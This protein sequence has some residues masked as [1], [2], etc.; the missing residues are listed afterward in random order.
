[1]PSVPSGIKISVAIPVRNEEASIRA[2][3]DSLL[4]QTLAP[5]EIVITDGGSTDSTAAMITEYVER[6]APIHLLRERP[7]M[8][9]RGRNLAA[10]AATNEWI[11]FIDAGTHPEANWLESLTEAVVVEPDIDMV[12]GSYQPITDTFFKE[13]AAIAYVPPPVRVDGIWMRPRSIVSVLMRKAVWQSVNG[14]PEDLRSAEDLLFLDQVEAAGARRAYA[15]K[16]VVNWNIQPGWWK[17]FERFVTY[18]RNNIRAGLWRSWQ[19]TIYLRYAVLLFLTIVALFRGLVWILVPTGLCLLMLLA[20]GVVAIKR[21]RHSYPASLT[22]NLLR[23]MV[24]VPLL[25]MIDLAAIVGGL[26]WLVKD[27]T[28][29][30]APAAGVSHDT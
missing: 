2:L 11:A 27:R 6:G 19:A 4:N 22:T 5:D 20:R 25:A 7:G 8:P 29:I 17:T 30:P 3:L 13:C 24:L 15:P 28:I 14:F 9:G 23:L 21:N 16:A 26:N 12:Y 1:M 10:A 18:S